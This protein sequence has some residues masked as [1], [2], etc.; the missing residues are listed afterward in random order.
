VRAD[1]LRSLKTNEGRG[2]QIGTYDLLFGDPGA[3]SQALARIEAVKADD[4]K[5]VAKQ[6]FEARNRTVVVLVPEKE[7]ATP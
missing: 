5:R 6:Y 3:M 1:L 2:E 4:V 7:G